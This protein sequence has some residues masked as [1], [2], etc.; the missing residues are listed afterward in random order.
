M[1]Y[2]EEMKLWLFDLAHGNLPDDEIVKGFIKHYVINGYTIHDVHNHIHFHTNYGL[3][4][5]K[6]AID[7]LNEA[8]IRFAERS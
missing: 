8:L 2:T 5:A 6:T 1:K 7:S 3:E 4:G